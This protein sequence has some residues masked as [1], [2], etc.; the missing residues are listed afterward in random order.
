MIAIARRRYERAQLVTDLPFP[1][2][3]YDEIN[4]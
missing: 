4:K 1:T 3:T 2:S